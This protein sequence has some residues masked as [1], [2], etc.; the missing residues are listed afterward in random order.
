MLEKLIVFVEEYSMEA[1]LELL[2]PKLLG[3]MDFEIRRFQCKDDLL[4]RLPQRLAWYAGWLPDTWRILVVVDRDDD[5]CQALK[6]QLETIAA[7][8]GLLSKTAAGIGQN[9]Q[10]A[11]RI[12]IEELEAWFFGDWP[13]VQAAYPRVPSTIPNK[14]A[15]RHPDTIVVGTWEALERILKKA[16]YFSTGLRKLECARTVASHM[17]PA[18]NTSPSFQAFCGAINATLA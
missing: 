13:A 18:R 10:V 3:A 11:N 16:G 2:L 7:T 15:F 9:F 17:E 12:A 4:K 14:A 5:D 1:S 8:A 6:R